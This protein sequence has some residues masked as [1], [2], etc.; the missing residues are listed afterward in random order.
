MAIVASI[1]DHAAG[2]VTFILPEMT[3]KQMEEGLETERVRYTDI[4]PGR[5][6]RLAIKARGNMDGSDT[7]L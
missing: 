7:M 3:E 1:P 5:V 4:I 2:G 6:Q